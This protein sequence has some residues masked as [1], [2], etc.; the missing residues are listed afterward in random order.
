MS[1]DGKVLML[2]QSSGARSA[3]SVARLRAETSTVTLGQVRVVAENAQ[4]LSLRQDGREVTVV[5][6]D[7]M[8]KAIGITPTADAVTIGATTTLF[9]APKGLQGFAVGPDGQQFV[10]VESP[11]A[12]G[13][14]LRILT[15]WEA[16]LK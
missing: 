11:F 5:G 8:V 2:L 10:I 14:T 7:G 6:P 12:Q 16:R 13:Q 1:V 3:V 9:Q 4:A 15:H